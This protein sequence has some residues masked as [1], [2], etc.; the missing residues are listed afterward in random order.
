[1]IILHFGH[2][3]EIGII[4]SGSKN[5][6]VPGVKQSKDIEQQFRKKKPLSSKILLTMGEMQSTSLN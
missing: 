2:C 5:A 4:S 6:A 3:M 1:M